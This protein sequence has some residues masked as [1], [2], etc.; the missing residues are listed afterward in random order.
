M[1]RRSGSVLLAM[2]IMS[3]SS[4]ALASP[5]AIGKARGLLA[6]KKPQAALA[7]LEPLLG[8][9]GGTPDF[10]YVY[11]LAANDSGKP[12]QAVYALERVLAVQPDHQLARLELA[13]SYFLLNE[14]GA[15][16]R[17]FE[18]VKASNP[19]REVIPTIDRFLAAIEERALQKQKKTDI[20]GYAQT[21]LGRDTNVN[22]ATTE[23]QVALPLLGGIVF[24]LNDDGRRRPDNFATLSGG[25]NITHR[26]TDSMTWLGGANASMRRNQREHAFNTDSLDFNAGGAYSNGANGYIGMVQASTM[27]LDGRSY[28]HTGGLALQWVYNVAETTQLA[29]FGQAMKIRYPD[30]TVRN[31]RR[32]MGGTAL[33]MR[34]E[35][36]MPASYFAGLYLGEEK[37]DDGAFSSLGY[38]LGGLRVGGEWQFTPTLKG[39]ANFSYERRR[40]KGEEALF[41]KKREDNQYDGRF[42]V[43]YTFAKDWQLAPSISYTRNESNIPINDYRRAVFEFAVR[44]EF[45]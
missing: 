2:L 12:G 33:A 3:I 24:D 34:T 26:A 35:G 29:T 28:R 42:G 8:E 4:V 43:G 10:D 7:A 30:Q 27:W 41:L 39:F 36:E 22:S 16:R 23:R 5:E 19:P 13:R 21:S 31:G 38:G 32:L 14:L 17:E 20:K 9:Y 15:S 25:V 40:Y 37:T 6:Q 1:H 44:S 45:Q 18:A 11:G